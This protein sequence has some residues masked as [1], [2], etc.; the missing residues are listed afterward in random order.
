MSQTLDC[1]FK[2]VM[3]LLPYLAGYRESYNT[4]HVLMRMVE[5]WRENLDKTLFVGA[6]LSDLFKAFD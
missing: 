5:K 2:I 4:Q 1:V 3:F 6:L